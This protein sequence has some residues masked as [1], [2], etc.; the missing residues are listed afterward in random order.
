MEPVGA[1]A[2]PDL[3]A[4]GRTQSSTTQGSAGSTNYSS[5][6]DEDIGET[7]RAKIKNLDNEGSQFNN[8][9]HAEEMTQHL[10][11]GLGQL[12][13]QNLARTQAQMEQFHSLALQS[14]SNNVALANAISSNNAVVMHRINQDAAS[15]SDRQKT[16]ADRNQD[17]ATDSQWNPIQQGTGDSLSAAAYPAN[18]A[19]DTASA[20]VAA[21]IPAINAAVTTA[22]NAA[23]VEV[24]KVINKNN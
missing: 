13:L 14:L 1:Y 16:M 4:Q 7:E 15:H 23:M 8:R 19:T 24:L 20:S 12:G 6:R 2:S 10:N 11:F 17:L 5:I 21:M 18:R 3:D 22:V 9:K